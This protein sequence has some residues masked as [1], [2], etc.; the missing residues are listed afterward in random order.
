MRVEIS[1]TPNLG[2]KATFTHTIESET[3]AYWEVTFKDFPE[4]VTE[5]TTLPDAV[6]EASDA[7]GEAIAGRVNRG[8]E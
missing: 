2:Y 4:I 1:V 3:V 7:L 5:G 8:S 6:R